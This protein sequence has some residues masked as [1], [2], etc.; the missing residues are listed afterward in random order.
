M[1]LSFCAIN[2]TSRP[3]IF[4]NRECREILGQK[5]SRIEILV[6]DKIGCRARISRDREFPTTSLVEIKT[7]ECP[8]YYSICVLRLA[9]FLHRKSMHAADSCNG[10]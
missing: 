7:K 10:Q 2:F 6:L 1:I 9:G 8:I 5:F 3:A 4:E